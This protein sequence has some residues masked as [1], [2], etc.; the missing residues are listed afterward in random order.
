MPGL[1]QF[2]GRSPII[3]GFW[4]MAKP[5]DRLVEISGQF[6]D[7]REDAG[8]RSSSFLGFGDQQSYMVAVSSG[9]PVD[10][11]DSRNSITGLGLCQ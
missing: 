5:D 8:N 1:D 7:L 11:S 6:F 3:S 4:L 10:P 2:V 9:Y